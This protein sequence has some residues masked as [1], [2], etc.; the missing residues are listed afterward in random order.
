MKIDSVQIENFRSFLAETVSFNDYT[1]LVGP[2]G[3]GK[4]TVLTA[5]NL[6]FRE[7]ENS[8]TDLAQLGEEDFH[9]KNTDK[10][11]RITVTFTDLGEEAEK[12]F[13]DYFRQGKLIVSSVAQFD[14]DTGKAEVKQ[15]GQRL[16]MKD[17]ARFFEALGDDKKVNEL[18]SIYSDL[19]S[20]FIDLPLPGTK[21]SMAQ[22][23]RGYE[24]DHHDQCE[25][26][27]SEDQ[28]YGF[29]RGVN[30]LAKH[31]Q[32]VYVP[33]VKD[34]ASEQ[35]EARNSA[36]GKLLA[37]TVRARMNFDEAVTTL[38]GQIQEQYQELLN[39][40]QNALN[41]LSDSLQRRL[42]E[43]AHPDARLRLEWKQD[44][45]K[46]VRVEEPWAHILAGEGGFE[47]ELSRF[48]HGFQ[49]SYLLALLQELARA[50][51]ETAPTL[52]LACEEPELYQHPPQARHLADVLDRLSDRLSR[53]NSQVL[54]STHNPLFVSGE[55]FEDVRMV[56]K[57]PDR[58]CSSVSHMSFAMIARAVGVATGEQSSKPEGVLAKVH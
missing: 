43:W 29:S 20:D 12:D 15:Y 54:V 52:I 58:S 26:I 10:P 2:N 41:E 34:A 24:A 49:R 23:L 32:W 28:F 16:G 36:L 21:D 13:A 22:A 7:S 3:A 11:I 56:R 53:T 44:P 9:H 55:G 5:L 48:G 38:R 35:V 30:R 57:T 33:A 40:H 19:Q 18:K 14:P 42:A 46:S 31:V 39:K 17:F 4:S 37:R 45:D 27:P 50:D 8:Q 1:C 25:L 47:G 6:F 51:V